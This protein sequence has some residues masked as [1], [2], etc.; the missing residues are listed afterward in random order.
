MPRKCFE[1]SP[2]EAHRGTRVVYWRALTYE[3]DLSTQE[4]QARPDARVPCAYADPER[5]GD[6][7]TPAPEGPHAAERL[8]MARGKAGTPRRRLTRSGDFERVYKEGSSRANRYLV[9]YEFPRGPEDGETRRLGVSVGKKV[10]GAVQ[11]NR[12]KRVLREAFWDIAERLPESHDYAL[13]ARRDALDLVE[14]GGKHAVIASLEE[15]LP[16]GDESERST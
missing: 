4:A 10:G 11:R 15:I 14:S 6:R 1:A 3:A 7:A 12:V 5:A 9:L 13:V 16:E 8:I 2:G